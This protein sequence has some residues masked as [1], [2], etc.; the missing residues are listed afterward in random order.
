MSNKTFYISGELCHSEGN[1]RLNI[2]QHG[3]LKETRTMVL[4]ERRVTVTEIA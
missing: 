4:E 2:N 1:E 3:K